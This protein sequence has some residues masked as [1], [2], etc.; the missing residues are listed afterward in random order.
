MQEADALL[1][2]G[3]QDNENLSKKRGL[4]HQSAANESPL[5]KLLLPVS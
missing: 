5:N 4:K 1:K 3:K 2:C